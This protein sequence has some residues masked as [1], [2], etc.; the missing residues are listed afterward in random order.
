MESLLEKLIGIRGS[1]ICT[2]KYKTD[3]KVKKNPYGKITKINTVQGLVNFYYNE[4]VKRRLLKEGKSEQ[5]FRS[6]ESWHEPVLV[7]GR[8]S[9]ICR[10]KKD[11]TKFYLR[12]MYLRKLGMSQYFVGNDPIEESKILQWLASGS[13]YSNQGLDKPLVFLTISLDNILEFV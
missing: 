1:R 8:I 4:G 9:P 11:I 12:F 13:S 6:G 7:G 5:D 3:A 2:V 10:N